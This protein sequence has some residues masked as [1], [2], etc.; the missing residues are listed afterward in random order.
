MISNAGIL[1][2]IA[3]AVS[4]VTWSGTHQPTHP[5]STGMKSYISPA[6]R[7][8][9]MADAGLSQAVALKMSM[10]DQDDPEAMGACIHTVSGYKMCN[11]IRVAIASAQ[12]LS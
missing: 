2:A 9:T 6:S 11:D 7:M 1:G 4:A 5:S 12:C 3:L 8:K 10:V